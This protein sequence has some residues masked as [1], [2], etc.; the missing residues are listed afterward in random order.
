MK[1]SLVKI[2]KDKIHHPI[3]R[4]I[5]RCQPWTLRLNTYPT[6]WKFKI[7]LNKIYKYNGYINRSH[8]GTNSPI[9]LDTQSL[10]LT[11]GQGGKFFKKFSLNGRPSTRN[12]NRTL[13]RLKRFQYKKFN[14]SKRSTDVTQKCRNL[15]N[16]KFYK[17]CDVSDYKIYLVWKNKVVAVVNFFFIDHCE[18]KDTSS[19]VNTTD[20]ELSKL[21]TDY[22]QNTVF[23]A[24]HH[25]ILG[26]VKTI[27][28]PAKLPKN[29]PNY[30]NPF[31]TPENTKNTVA[32]TV[33][34]SPSEENTS[35]PLYYQNW[36][37][38]LRSRLTC[39]KVYVQSGRI[40]NRF[41]L[42]IRMRALSK[43]FRQ[44]TKL[45]QQFRRRRLSHTSLAS[46]KIIIL[47]RV[48][49]LQELV[50]NFPIL[51]VEVG[52]ERPKLLASKV[53]NWKEQKVEPYALGLQSLIKQSSKDAM[54]RI[55]NP[56]N[57][58]SPETIQNLSFVN[59]PS[60]LSIRFRNI[61]VTLFLYFSLIQTLPRARFSTLNPVVRE[62]PNKL[63]TNAYVVPKQSPTYKL[64][65]NFKA[66]Y[67]YVTLLKNKK[68]RRGRKSNI[69]FSLN[70]GLFL[71]FFNYKKSLKKTKSLKLILMR[72]LRK[73]LIVSRINNFNLYVK[74][75]S[76]QLGRLLQILQK[77][78]NHSF[79]DPLTN[80]TIDEE[81]PQCPK[82]L[83]NFIYMIFLKNKPYGQMK[84]KN[85]G[86]LKR[87]IRRRV[88]KL[89]RIID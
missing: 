85:E 26:A 36:Y 69:F 62:K 13:K 22:S 32:R 46:L 67:L 83:F 87:K 41:A 8:W 15:S 9:F 23:I 64:M 44:F 74:K 18:I 5:R 65:F 53:E 66:H 40:R 84:I 6:F 14:N 7:R 34:D 30:E 88:I 71:K 50:P 81:S 75:T 79:I 49:V 76:D 42:L 17:T 11:I 56:S 25:R 33:D 89:N 57:M 73:L 2:H 38:Q 68:K 72:Y 27:F 39:F 86:R 59:V 80:K 20:R 21:L 16:L 45:L 35:T 77:P 1:Y 24:N 63:K 31:N 29:S 43:L 51:E 60:S 61:Y 55:D 12:K 10:K 58:N 70:T 3:N 19:E 82:T 37:F 48:R 47:G 52:R 78:L 28:S 4:S 54:S